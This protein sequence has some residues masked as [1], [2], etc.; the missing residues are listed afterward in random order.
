ML[1]A[2]Q[3]QTVDSQ[4]ALAHNVAA[5]WLSVVNY[6]VGETL[7]LMSGKMKSLY[8]RGFRRITAH[9]PLLELGLR[10]LFIRC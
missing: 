1:S 8:G 2:S 5:C 10:G 6:P 4:T 7:K 9:R 3:A